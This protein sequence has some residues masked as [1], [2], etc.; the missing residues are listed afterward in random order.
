MKKQRERMKVPVS[1]SPSASIEHAVS[2]QEV[3]T[4]TASE[5]LEQEDQQ[6]PQDWLAKWPHVPDEIK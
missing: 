2:A 1:P 4:I 5:A 6:T 3:S